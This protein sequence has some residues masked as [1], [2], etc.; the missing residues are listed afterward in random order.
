[1]QIQ[2][3]RFSYGAPAEYTPEKVVTLA[4]HIAEL[5]ESEACKQGY[6]LP[7]NPEQIMERMEAGLI[8]LA[9][10]DLGNQ[11]DVFLGC[12]AAWPLDEEG[13]Y[14]EAGS[15]LVVE[16]CRGHKIGTELSRLLLQRCKELGI[17]LLLTTKNPIAA[18]MFEHVG[19]E[20]ASYA[21]VPVQ[22]KKPLCDD[23]PCHIAC[24]SGCCSSDI[25]H[26]GNCRLF[27]S[28]PLK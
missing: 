26:G 18:L 12:F 27:A 23:A 28:S 2:N 8:V 3:L 22:V 6:V 25:E 10:G 17:S 15:M 7:K 20:S 5:L 4:T 11:K 13:T 9:F 21:L 1:M 14:L 16:E 24:S 19:F